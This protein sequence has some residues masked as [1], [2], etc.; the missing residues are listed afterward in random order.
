MPQ[1]VI[2]NLTREDTARLAPAIARAVSEPIGVP[3]DWIVVE[4]ADTAFFRNGRPDPKSA[5]V[6][7]YWKKRTRQLQETVAK[8]LGDLLM[9]EGF[10]PVE[11]VYVNLDM[12]DVYEYKAE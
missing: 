8:A 4:H 1:V 11:I 10:S 9:G 7:I 6:W 2:K 5:M 12:D 3:M